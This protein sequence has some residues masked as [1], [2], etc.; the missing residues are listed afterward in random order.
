MARKGTSMATDPYEFGV[1]ARADV[2]AVCEKLTGIIS[3]ARAIQEQFLDDPDGA[4]V[5]ASARKVEQMAQET[6]RRAG[7][8]SGAA[9]ELQTEALR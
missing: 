7:F 1:A 3:E 9:S 2:E 5:R 8:V 4:K 6:M